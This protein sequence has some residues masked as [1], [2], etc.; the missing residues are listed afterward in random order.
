MLCPMRSFLLLRYKG[1]KT[2]TRST[3]FFFFFYLKQN[4]NHEETNYS[5][6]LQKNWKKLD[7]RLQPASRRVSIRKLIIFLVLDTGT[8]TKSN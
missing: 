1:D 3:L 7:L 8:M 6:T 4:G 2:Q 5:K